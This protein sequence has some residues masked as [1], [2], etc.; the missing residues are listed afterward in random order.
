V[1]TISEGRDEARFSVRFGV[2]DEFDA[3]EGLR[4]G[5]LNLRE[6]S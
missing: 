3:C 1:A 6:L 5:S 2:V 4:K